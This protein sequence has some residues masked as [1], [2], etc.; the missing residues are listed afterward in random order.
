MSAL[1]ET[2]QEVSECITAGQR[3]GVGGWKRD[4]RLTVVT[5]GSGVSRPRA[6]AGE[7]APRL[8]AAAAV[9][10]QVGEA[11]A[12]EN[13]II[14][15]K[16]HSSLN[17][18]A[19]LKCQTVSSAATQRILNNKIPVLANKHKLNLC[20][21]IYLFFLQS[22]GGSRGILRLDYYLIAANSS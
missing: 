4:E 10:T 12:R 14:T 21:F 5:G 6:L 7:G 11:S 13:K 19:L 15:I 9:L 18:L 2:T 17:L 20:L 1:K 3:V 16:F 8:G 22:S